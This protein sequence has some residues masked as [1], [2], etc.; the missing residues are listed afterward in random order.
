MNSRPKSRSAASALRARQRRKNVVRR[1]RPAARKRPLV[2]QLEPPRFATAF[3]ALVDVT[4]AAAVT[5]DDGSANVHA[6][7]PAR[8]GTARAGSR[9]TALARNAS[10]LRAC[11]ARRARLRA[12]AEATFLELRDERLGRAQMHAFERPVVAGIRQQIFRALEHP[13]VLLARG[14]L[15]AVSLR[16]PLPLALARARVPALRRAVDPIARSLTRFELA[17]RRHRSDEL[18]PRR[19]ARHR[20]RSRTERLH[21]R[22]HVR[23]GID[24]PHQLRDLFLGAVLRPLEH[25]DVV[26]VREMRPDHQQSGEMD[27]A[28]RDA[29]EH[30]GKRSRDARRLGPPERGVF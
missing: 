28:G 9:C 2:V 3:T 5:L 25:V 26:F 18:A 23:Q 12:G 17:H 14:E 15:H 4:A 20:E 11:L 29:I 7:M 1:R 6:D 16:R 19:R 27:L 10:T 24:L 22:R 30:G 13:D 8:R 21:A